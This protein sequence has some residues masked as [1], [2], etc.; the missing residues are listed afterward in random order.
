MG[1]Q[2]DIKAQSASKMS[3][4]Q[5]MQ[6]SLTRLIEVAA[7]SPHGT[8]H[9]AEYEA[10]A[11]PLFD[12]SFSAFS[13]DTL[14]ATPRGHVCIEDLNPGDLVNTITGKPS[15]IIWIGSS[16]IVPAQP[17]H[18]TP[19]IRIMADT[20]GKSCPSSFLTIGPSARLLQTPTKTQQRQNGTRV[21]TSANL[22]VDHLNVIKLCPQTP[23]RLFHMCLEQHAIIDVGGIEMETYHPGLSFTDETSPENRRLFL[24]MFP[25]ITHL[26]DFG[27]LA[28]PRLP[29]VNQGL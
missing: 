12:N 5:Y 11:L 22:F 16:S 7:L 29:E 8:M 4:P 27:P 9:I 23:I 14:I 21:L 24:S 19:L 6:S 10:P 28:Y 20:F 26:S 17:D 18:E 13:G 25:R 2:K 1:H 15:K 3:K